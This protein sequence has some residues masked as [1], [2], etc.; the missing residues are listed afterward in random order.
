ML[1]ALLLAE[2]QGYYI[3]CDCKGCCLGLTVPDAP[4]SA[5][6][7]VRLAMNSGGSGEELHGCAG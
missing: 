3:G 7:E 2:L 4:A 5:L 6:V 1:L